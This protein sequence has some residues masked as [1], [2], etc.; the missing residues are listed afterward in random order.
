MRE[1]LA[2]GCLYFVLAS[3]LSLAGFANGMTSAQ[4]PKPDKPEQKGAP[5]EKT[6]KLPMDSEPWK[7]VFDWLAE[8][9]GKPVNRDFYPAG[10]FTFIGPAS[11]EYTIQEVI[12]IINDTMLGE[13]QSEKCYLSCDERSF[14][15]RKADENNK[16]LKQITLRLSVKTGGEDAVF[17]RP[18]VVKE[19]QLTTAQQTKLKSITAERRKALLPLFLSGE[20]FEEIE[21][22]VSAH[23]KESYDLLLAVLNEKQQSQLKELLGDPY[24]CLP[25][26]NMRF[27]AN[28]LP[29]EPEGARLRRPP[30]VALH[31]VLLFRYKA[32]LKELNP[33]A[34]QVK[35]LDELRDRTQDRLE[36]GL[37]GTEDWDKQ[38]MQQTRENEK[39]LADILDA[40]QLAR[41]KQIVLQF[42]QKARSGQ[43][44]EEPT[45]LLY[46]CAEVAKEL[47]LS[48]KQLERILKGADPASVMDEIQNKKLVEML[49]KPLR[50][51][52]AI[53][54]PPALGGG[55]MG[56]RSGVLDYL[57]E[58]AV[59]EELKLSTEQVQKVRKLA[60]EWQTKTDDF[61][62][63]N[64][65]PWNDLEEWLK[66]SIAD[67]LDAKQLKRLRQ[68]ELQQKYRGSTFFFLQ[69]M[70]P[71]VKKALEMAGDLNLPL[72]RV[73]RANEEQTRSLIRCELYGVVDGKLDP[74]FRKTMEEFDKIAVAKLIARLNPK[75]QEKVKELLGEPFLKELRHGQD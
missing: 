50:I 17:L 30:S 45:T 10:T 69:L 26:K 40:Q 64:A 44:V 1:R 74:D 15:L 52:A 75:Q 11:K 25:P 63:S 60:M 72:R 39:A 3:G 6:V 9:T 32:V 51:V 4:E 54:L 23:T 38:I 66:K 53:Q 27:A 48:D 8:T 37:P 36:L 47:Q 59:H 34:D 14:T 55:R 58:E 73:W 41:F 31:G 62:R 49:G 42:F 56:R 28:P 16:R 2:R 65:T 24:R 43:W 71:E 22:K 68:I 21:K 12:D 57:R 35:R 70:D 33:T 13:Y 5:K 19:L 20:N 18:E 67:I 7:A 61:S 29:G 46:E